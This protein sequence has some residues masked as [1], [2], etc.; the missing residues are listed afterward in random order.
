MSSP[1]QKHGSYEHIM[2]SFDSHSF[3]VRCREKGKVSDPCISHDCQACNSLME[4]Q[5][6]QL[7]TPSYRLKKEKRELQKSIHTPRKDSDSSSH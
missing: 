5:C 4:E 1:G 7:S 3:C 2:T 6:L